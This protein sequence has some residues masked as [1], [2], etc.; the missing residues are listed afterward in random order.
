MMQITAHV[1]PEAGKPWPWAQSN[2]LAALICVVA[3][4]NDM[5]LLFPCQGCVCMLLAHFSYDR[6]HLAQE[7]KN[8]HFL[9]FYSKGCHLLC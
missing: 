5:P 4:D 7:A 8:I 9:S 2:P 3:V 1:K 6:D